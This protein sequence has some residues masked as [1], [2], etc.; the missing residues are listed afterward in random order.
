MSIQLTD[1]LTSSGSY[2]ERAKSKELTPELLSNANKLLEKVNA[3]F[4]E[5]GVKSVK[6]SSGFRTTEANSA[7][8]NSAKKS[9]HCLCKAIDLMDDK[10]QTL[11]KLVA[12]KPDLLRKYGLF[13]EDLGSTKGKNSN[14]VHI[15]Y[16]D[17]S[18][19]PNRSFKP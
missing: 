2:P 7:T 6:I 10:N 9:S 19:R 12:S 15:D 1:Y 3:L 17:R 4:V 14:W 16:A 11:G 5:L 13:I 18:D 8:P